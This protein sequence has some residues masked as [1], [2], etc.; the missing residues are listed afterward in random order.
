[1]AA[2]PSAVSELALGHVLFIDIV[3]YSKLLVDEQTDSLQQ[4]N[5]IVRNTEQVVSAERKGKLIRLPT[6]DEIA[7]VFF[8]SPEAPLNC[9]LEISRTLKE[10][11]PIKLRMGI[12]TGPINQVS[13]VRPAAALT[14]LNG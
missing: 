2:E 8:T 13:D 3:G 6:G 11:S 5:R 14:S 9:A 12:H 4:L 1:M 7:L 10:A